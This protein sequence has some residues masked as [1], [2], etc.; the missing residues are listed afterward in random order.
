MRRKLSCK[1]D[2]L[3]SGTKCVSVNGYYFKVPTKNQQ[4]YDNITISEDLSSYEEITIM[5]FMKFLGSISQR[6]GIVPILYFYEDQNYLGWDIEKESFIINIL[7]ETIFDYD[8]SRLYIGKWS[9]FSISIYFSNY[10]MKFPNMIQFMIDE[11]I[12]QSTIEIQNLN[13]KTFNINKIRINNKMSAIL[14]NLK[15]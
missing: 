6:I 14:Y 3:I 10:A 9:F 13:K 12:I 11:N 1:N 7:G 5:F 4:L 2:Y 15:S 8:K